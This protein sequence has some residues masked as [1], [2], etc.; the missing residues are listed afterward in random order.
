[1]DRH[2]LRVENGRYRKTTGTSKNNRCL[3]L[4]PA[5]QQRS[6]GRI[7]V[8]RLRSGA[9]AP[10]HIISWLPHDCAASINKDGTVLSLI[11]S[12]EA[13]FERDGVF[14]TREQAAAL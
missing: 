2:T 5:F 12:V 11:P 7:E 13:G 14:F 4:H 1:M 3:G 6:T 10:A 9:P 8:A